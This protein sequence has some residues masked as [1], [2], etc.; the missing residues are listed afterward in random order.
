MYDTSAGRVILYGIVP[1]G[2][3]FEQVNKVLGKKE[4]GKLVDYI[5]KK[6]GN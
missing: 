4:L 5:Y 3:D 1:E 6:L 2:I